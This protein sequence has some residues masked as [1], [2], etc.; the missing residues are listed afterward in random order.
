MRIDTYTKGI[1]IVIAICL[2]GYSG[3]LELLRETLKAEIPAKIA[4]NK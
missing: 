2:V 4:V 1:L 3:E